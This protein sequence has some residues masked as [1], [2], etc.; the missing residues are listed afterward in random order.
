MKKSGHGLPQ[1]G[2]DFASTRRADREKTPSQPFRGLQVEG[3]ARSH[4]R[5]KP[6]GSYFINSQKKSTENAEPLLWRRISAIRRGAETHVQKRWSG[7]WHGDR[8]YGVQAG[9]MRFNVV[10]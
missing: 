4:P 3:R 6:Q 7:V 2:E 10:R 1:L 5:L 9:F 8:R